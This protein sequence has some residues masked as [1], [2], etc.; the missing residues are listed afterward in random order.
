MEEKAEESQKEVIKTKPKTEPVYK[1]SE[2]LAQ[3]VINFLG[4]CPYKQVADLV[5]AM[6]QLEK[7]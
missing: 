1:I 5:R 7:I 4:N 2:S 3:A 6:T